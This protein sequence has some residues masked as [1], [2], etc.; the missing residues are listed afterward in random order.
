MRSRAGVAGLVVLL[1]LTACRQA[2]GI[3]PGLPLVVSKGAGTGTD[4][5]QVTVD[6]EGLLVITEGGVTRTAVVAR[7]EVDDLRHRITKARLERVRSTRAGAG[8]PS[9]L[10]LSG[11]TEI[12]VAVDDVPPRLVPVLD[13]VRSR[14]PL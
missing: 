10:L 5:V 13:W 7:A 11:D 12:S 6:P 9:Y 3:S 1:V 14:S 2:P 8:E 4:V